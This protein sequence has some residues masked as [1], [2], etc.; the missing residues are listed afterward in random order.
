MSVIDTLQILIEADAHGIEGVLKKTLQT[1]TGTVNEINKQE[2]DWTS[3]FTRSVSPAIISGIAATFAFAIQQSLSF[4]QAMNT[5]GTAAGESSAQI[6]QTGQ[7]ALAMSSH[8][9]SSAQEIANSMMQV[10]TLFG[11]NTQESKDVTE[12][13]TKLADSGFGNLNDIVTASMGIFRSWGVTTSSQAITVLTDLMHA[14]EGAKE[15]IPALTSQFSSFS[16]QLPTADKN[17][18]SFNGLISTFGSEIANLGVAG[19]QG[20]FAALATSASSAAGPME[21]MG[22]SF[23]KVQK[24]LLTDGGLT[25][26]NN[27]SEYLS[28]MGPGAALVATNFGLSATQVGQFQANAKGLTKIATDAKDIATNTQSIT[29][30]WNQSD[31]AIREF[32]IDYHKLQDLFNSSHISDAFMGIAK[33]LG[34]VIDEYQKSF[35]RFTDSI[36]SN[37]AKTQIFGGLNSTIQMAGG[38]SGMFDQSILDRIDQKAEQTGLIDSLKG[39]LESGIKGDQY[40][41]TAKTFNLTIPSGT[42]GLSPQQ[43]AQQIYRNFQGTP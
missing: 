41:Y 26:I 14:A 31:S 23:E 12:A 43:I 34:S 21:I 2:V 40:A 1:V 38:K 36:G 17:L 29:D 25:A 10:S 39:A 7:A 4:S 20:I 8:V 30:A 28:R 11:T 16:D 33:G 19:A 3:I 9:G 18:T 32:I 37:I 42:T 5:T 24:S 15:S 6:A 35:T 13:M 27:T 22:T